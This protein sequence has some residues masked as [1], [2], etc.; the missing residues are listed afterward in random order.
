MSRKRKASEDA[1]NNKPSNFAMER[2]FREVNNA[3]SALEDIMTNI[4]KE[5]E[6]EDNVINEVAI[7]FGVTQSSA[8]E[9]FRIVVPQ[10]ARGHKE[11]NHSQNLLKRQQKILR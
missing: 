4:N 8:K 2:H 9:M 7:L 1:E 10:L 5:F 6:Q 11:S 3:Y